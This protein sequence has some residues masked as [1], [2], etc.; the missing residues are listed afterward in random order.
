[1]DLFRS[2]PEVSEQGAARL[3][4]E[5]FSP[6]LTAAVPP[7][8]ACAAGADVRGWINV[9]AQRAKLGLSDGDALLQAWHLITAANPFPATLGRICPHPC[10]AGCNRTSH[11]GPIAINALERFVGDWA[12]AKSLP[13]Q[14]PT[15]GPYP[16]SIGAIGA[17][18]AGLSFA[19]QM[20]RRGYRVTVYEKEDKPGGML[21]QGIPEYRLPERVLEAE[22]ARVLALG[23]E[24]RLGTAAGDSITVKQLR[25]AHNYLFVGIGAGRGLKLGIPDEEGPACYSGTEYLGRLNRGDAV[26]FEGPVVVV[27]GGNTAMDAARCARRSG[28]PV[29]VLYRRTQEEMPAIPSEVE[30]ALAEGVRI[31]FL[32]APTSVLRENGRVKGVTVQRMQLG[33]PDA[34]G[35]RSPV[36]IAGAS[37]ELPCR[38]LIAAVSQQSD[39]Q[40]L[41]GLRS[42]ASVGGTEGPFVEA[43]CGGG[44]VFGPGIAAVAIAQGRHAAEVVHARLRGLAIPA[45]EA[46]VNGAIDIKPEYYAATDRVDIPCSPVELRLARPEIEVL[47]TIGAKEF[48]EEVS[49]C[50]SCGSCFGCERCF[51][52]CNPAGYTRTMCPKPGAYFELNL[53]VCEGC[54]KCIELCPCGFLTLGPM[55]EGVVR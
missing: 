23:V 38:A 49:R 27:G 34:S 40:G 10:E 31:Q 29:V 12:L 3:F 2:A 55:M 17:G 1:M 50:F 37:Y 54:R 20:A 52:F 9:I 47:R 41:A 44:D 26:F 39:W 46:A 6:R 21:Y 11:G 15:E 42:G 45:A 28:V 18:P 16:E 53:A 24:L 35:R 36:P 48:F 8:A 30:D 33:P 25:A 4:Q 5:Q 32:S 19:Y 22:I 43:V 7:C 13:L 14:G 51:M